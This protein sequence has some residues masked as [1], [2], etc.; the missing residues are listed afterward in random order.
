MKKTAPFVIIFS[1]LLSG[2][3]TAYFLEGVKYDSKE[4]FVAARAAMNK[5][6]TESITVLPA[7]LVKRKLIA[8]IPS[9]ETIYKNRYSMIMAS[10][11]NNRVTMDTLRNNP[12]IA[13]LN[14][15]YRHLAEFIKRK[16][17]YTSFELVEYEILSAP[18][19]SADTDIFYIA[20]AEAMG[21]KDMLYLT[22]QKNGKQ[23]V[24]YDM[25]NPKCEFVRDSFFSSI[26][27]LAL[28]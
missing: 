6:C 11:P 1:L 9:Q 25:S 21:G 8:M 16:N 19:P 22:T 15:N 24:N 14:E 27:T 28:Q 2:C 23:V 5:R 4:S 3:G 17:I 18:Q 20:M 10:S 13:G 26:Q 7:P 12:L